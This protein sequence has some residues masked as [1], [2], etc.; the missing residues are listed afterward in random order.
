MP[1]V[2]GN[3]DGQKQSL[4]TLENATSSSI[5]QSTMMSSLLRKILYFVWNNGTETCIK[6][7]ISSRSNGIDCH[8]ARRN[9]PLTVDHDALRVEDDEQEMV[10]SLGGKLLHQADVTREALCTKGELDKTHLSLKNKAGYIMGAAAVLAC[11]GVGTG[12]YVGHRAEYKREKNFTESQ[13]GREVSDFKNNNFV[14][15]HSD[16]YP[17]TVIDNTHHK[18]HIYNSQAVVT[19]NNKIIR[20]RNIP[21]KAKC[22]TYTGTARSL[23]KKEVAC[24]F[25]TGG[26]QPRKKQI[27]YTAFRYIY[28]DKQPAKCKTADVKNRCQKAH[29]DSRKNNKNKI[30]SPMVLKINKTLCLCPPPEGMNVK[31]VPP[32]FP[33]MNDQRHNLSSKAPGNPTAA[34]TLHSVIIT[35]VIDEVITN[36]TDREAYPIGLSSETDTHRGRMNE[37]FVAPRIN[38]QPTA[39]DSDGISRLSDNSDVKIEKMYDFSC[40][41]NRN[42][43]SWADLIRHFGRTLSFPVKTMAE[44]SQILYHYNLH[45]KGCPS[46]RHSEDLAGITRKI[47]SVLTQILTLL[48]YSKPVTILQLIIGPALEVFADSLEGKS[49]DSQ[50]IDTINQQILFM[51]KHSIS[52]LSPLQAVNLHKSASGISHSEQKFISLNSRLAIKLKGEYHYLYE[53]MSGYPTIRDGLY[54]KPVYYN[55]ALRGWNFLPE[56]AD[57]LYSDYNRALIERYRDNMVDLS[58]GTEIISNEGLITV[59]GLDIDSYMKTYLYMNGRFVQIKIE[60]V[61][62]EE[63]YYPFLSAT[64][65]SNV[66]RKDVLW[67]FEQESTKI[68]YEFDS[69]LETADVL[70]MNN[71]PMTN[72][73]A[74]GF[75]YDDYGEK[76]IKRKGMYYPVERSIWG[77]DFIKSGHIKYVI[78]N[79]ATGFYIKGVRLVGSE[80][81]V[82][83]NSDRFIA[84]S[85]RNKI[86]EEGIVLT[87]EIELKDYSG[88]IATLTSGIEGFRLNDQLYKLEL[89]DNADT[90]NVLLKTKNSDIKL[91][92]LNNAVIEGRKLLSWDVDELDQY[93]NCIYKRTPVADSTCK[94]IYMTNKI[95][96]IFKDGRGAAK[97]DPDKLFMADAYFPGAYR[98]IGTEKIYFKYDEHYFAA[99]WI[100]IGKRLLSH[101]SLQIY[102]IQQLSPEKVPICR[103]VS[104]EESERF[105]IATEEEEFA[106]R[107]SMAVETSAGALDKF[108]YPGLI[109]RLRARFEAVKLDDIELSDSKGSRIRNMLTA[110]FSDHNY[111]VSRGLKFVSGITNDFLVEGKLSA[112]EHLVSAS[113]R[114]D[115]SL[116]MIKEMDAKTTKGI[117]FRSQLEDYFARF[118]QIKDKA[119]I[120]TMISRYRS[121]VILAKGFMRESFK[122]NYQNIL[123]AAT[124]GKKLAVGDGG[125]HEIQTLLS[126]DEISK[127]PYMVSTFEH[128]TLPAV[129]TVFPEKLYLFNPEHQQSYRHY[130]AKDMS[131]TFIHEFTH[132]AAVTQDYMYFTYKTDGTAISAQDMSKEFDRNIA[133]K[134]YNEDL[135]FLFQQYFSSLGK[136]IP[137]DLSNY[138]KSNSALKSYILMN[139]AASYEV[140]LR[141]IAKLVSTGGS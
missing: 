86:E 15:N 60:R 126:D 68:D 24:P 98:E 33:N 12:L 124:E 121:V 141:D 77:D 38:Q 96:N 23:T 100:E 117:G 17:A 27:K 125:Y 21:A 137:A 79:S 85:L 67:F 70:K 64:H 110:Y 35:E 102:K 49:I 51:A 2:N 122:N 83:L 61:Y 91:Y 10:L 74:D 78:S 136:D 32:H 19:T 105:Y 131:D 46:D 40:I 106:R 80:L 14:M 45:R 107:V 7:P 92:F 138:L 119:V 30:V 18:R 5:Y 116:H 115:D 58:K 139:N 65:Y 47:D 123:F 20:K 3:I 8:C 37:H 4:P 108:S 133:I 75:S 57:G 25:A 93:G 88:N 99:E 53:N 41:V 16:P 81:F 130:P 69:F 13:T 134:S 43:L 22:Y 140:F 111:E 54:D 36:K 118:L 59:A 89:S 28:T 42:N 135:D 52:S 11:A 95:K 76:Y 132:A 1:I 94:P 72:I 66:I 104:V 31:I 82:K 62:G 90:T 71:V 55:W 9:V 127:V 50:K 39:I 6:C 26:K 112:K 129:V 44:E 34:T 101:N 120:N 114:L 113:R 109:P 128:H 87:G 103:L 56:G 29:A 84:K 48:P 73:F 63:V 97:P